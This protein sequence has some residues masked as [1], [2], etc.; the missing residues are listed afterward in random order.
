MQKEQAI[1]L[2]KGR[3]IDEQRNKPNLDWQEIAASKIYSQWSEYFEGEKIK[4]L[5][6]LLSDISNTFL[7]EDNLKKAYSEGDRVVFRAIG[8]TIK[9]FPIT[10]TTSK[11]E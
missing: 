8:E 6:Q 3:I 4:A 9:N 2:I 11:Q 7:N 10:Q 1:A 5:N